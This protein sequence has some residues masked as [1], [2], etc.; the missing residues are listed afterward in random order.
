MTHGGESDG[1]SLVEVLVAFAIA[2]LGLVT[3]YNALAGHYRQVGEAG[4][5][6]GTLAHA[7]SH[8]EMIGTSI[9]PEPGKTAGRYDNGSEWRL[10]ISPLPSN[11]APGV[12]IVRPMRVVLEAFSRSGHRIVRL[13]SIRLATV[14]PR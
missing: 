8:L 13:K 14:T 2:S 10:T 1:F 12:R 6:L 7:Q 5:A 3:F 4:V 9:D 11:D